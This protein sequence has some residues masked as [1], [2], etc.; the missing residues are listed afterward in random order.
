MLEG[1]FHLHEQEARQVMTPT[2]ALVTVN[3]DETVEIGAAPVHRVRAHAPA[4]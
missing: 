1:V 4:S 3:S 2:P